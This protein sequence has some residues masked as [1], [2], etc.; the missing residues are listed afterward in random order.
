MNC[1][2]IWRSVG[3]NTLLQHLRVSAGARL[4]KGHLRGETG[5]KPHMSAVFPRRNSAFVH[6]HH[7]MDAP[8]VT[9]HLRNQETH[10]PLI[11][12]H[13]MLSEEP[14]NAV[15]VF[16]Y[17]TIK[18]IKTILKF[19]KLNQFLT[20]SPVLSQSVLSATKWEIRFSSS[21]NKNVLWW[22]YG[23]GSHSQ[24]YHDT[25]IYSLLVP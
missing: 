16:T 23:T 8:I 22:S 18:M 11:T 13:C 3:S 7:G 5:H 15:S 14:N 1:H 2:N 12:K 24:R 17:C 21:P 10:L 19:L 6:K 9:G 25:L 4:K 20:R